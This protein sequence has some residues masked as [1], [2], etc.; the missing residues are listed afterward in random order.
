MGGPKNK[1][2]G[3]AWSTPP[4]ALIVLFYEDSQKSPA[5]G[6]EKKR[7]SLGPYHAQK[8]V[9]VKFGLTGICQLQSTGMRVRLLVGH[10]AR[11]SS[12]GWG[13]PGPDQ[14]KPGPS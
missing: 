11:I 7:S 4:C 14:E 1:I 8:K 13:F 6:G 5:L 2:E 12:V 3:P 9:G 10:L